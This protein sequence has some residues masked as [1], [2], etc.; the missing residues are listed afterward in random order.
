MGTLHSLDKHNSMA[1]SRLERIHKGSHNTS[2]Q[3]IVKQLVD[4]VAGIMDNEK[5][6]LKQLLLKYRGILSQ[7]A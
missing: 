4:R 6:E 5:D 2:V 7:C 3:S 1:C